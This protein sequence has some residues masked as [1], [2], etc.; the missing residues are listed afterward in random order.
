MKSSSGS[1]TREGR[2]IVIALIINHLLL[3]WP[4]Q[5][6]LEGS[7][8]KDNYFETLNDNQ[9]NAIYFFF[10]SQK[11][12][13]ILMNLSSLYSVTTSKPVFAATFLITMVSKVIEVHVMFFRDSET[14]HLYGHI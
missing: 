8:T 2:P 9:L 13:I 12:I 14:W 5:H 6:V 1:C 7:L 10:V 3:L 11:I 4:H